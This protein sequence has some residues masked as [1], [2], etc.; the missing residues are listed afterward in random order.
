[1]KNGRDK[2]KKDGQGEEVSV[3]EAV[4]VVSAEELR[5]IEEKR[6]KKFVG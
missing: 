3:D 2:E 5:G 1:M 6:E 4:G